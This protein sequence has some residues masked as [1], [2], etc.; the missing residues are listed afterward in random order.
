MFVK[1]GFRSSISPNTPNIVKPGMV[2]LVA[3]MPLLV[4]VDWTEGL[5]RNGTV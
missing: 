3:S 2:G 1:I 5:R 4:S